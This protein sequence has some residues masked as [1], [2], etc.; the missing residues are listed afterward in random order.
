[1][2]PVAWAKLLLDLSEFDLNPFLAWPSALRI[3]VGCSY[4]QGVP[5]KTLQW[6]LDNNLLLWPAREAIPPTYHRYN[7]VL[8]AP[9]AI[10]TELLDAFTSMGLI[11]SQP[12]QG[13]YDLIFKTQCHRLLTPELVHTTIMVRFIASCDTVLITDRN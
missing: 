5:R 4:W 10:A 13:V 2:I 3:P 12:P 6:I 1:M 7:E 11:V 8:I 9:P